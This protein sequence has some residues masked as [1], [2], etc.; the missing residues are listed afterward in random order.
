MPGESTQSTSA[1]HDLLLEFIAG[2]FRHERMR[3]D[4]QTVFEW[5]AKLPKDLDLENQRAFLIV[6][7]RAI[8]HAVQEARQDHRRLLQ[9]VP[10]VLRLAEQK[11]DNQMND[12]VDRLSERLIQQGAQRVPQPTTQFTPGPLRNATEIGKIDLNRAFDT[13][14][15]SNIGAISP[16]R[17]SIK[18]SEQV[19][20]KLRS[21]KIGGKKD[22]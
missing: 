3:Q 5:I 10:E 13:P 14:I 18:R 2:A 1:S 20:S 8:N 9:K 17:R 4:I 16:T 11:A 22:E 12:L 7:R 21:L 6:A 15:E 19:A